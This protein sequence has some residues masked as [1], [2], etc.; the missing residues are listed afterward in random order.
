MRGKDRVMCSVKYN[1]DWDPNKASSNLLKH[2][3]SFDEATTVFRDACMLSIYDREHSEEEDRWISI[4]LSETG[5]VL[6]VCHTFREEATG[7]SV[8]RIFSTRKATKNEVMHYER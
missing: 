6:V 2:G 7:T 8:I 5:R 3:L 1:F 4:G